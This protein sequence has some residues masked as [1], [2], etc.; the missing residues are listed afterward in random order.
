MWINRIELTNWR[1]YEHAVFNIPR[2]Q[3]AKTN[4]VLIGAKNG[5][6]KTSLLEAVT[7]CL[8]GKDGLGF[9]GR[10]RSGN[11]KLPYGD[12]LR[13]A[14][15]GLADQSSL[16]ASAAVTFTME[17]G[18][19]MSVERTWHFKA[20]RDFREDELHIR[21][22]GSP[23]E[24]PALADLVDRAAFL[25][26]YVAEN[27]LPPSLSPFFLFDAARVQQMAR[28]DM[29]EQVR[30]GI[31]AILGVPVIN[32]VIRD[33]HDYAGQRYKQAR[34]GRAT[35][36]KMDELQQDIDKYA[37]ES[38]RLSDEII[39]V[40]A[41]LK[42][43]EEEDETLM[44]R[45]ESMGGDNAAGVLELREKQGRLEQNQNELSEAL[46]KS[47][48]G[49]FA[50]S[51][52]S[53]DM[54]GAAVS[55]LR[56][57][58]S[59]MDWERDKK[60]GADSYDKFIGNLEQSKALELPLSNDQLSVL[61]DNIKA[62]WDNVW[63]PMP[64]ECAKE[65][66]STA[67][68]EEE[69]ADAIARLESLSNNFGTAGLKDILDKIESNKSELSVI[70][71]QIDDVHGA[72]T[73]DARQLKDQLRNKRDEIA[74]L[75]RK[76]GDYAREKVSVDAELARVRQEWGR[77]VKQREGQA[78][79]MRLAARA[80][81]AASA[82]DDIVKKSYSR[83]VSNIAQGMTDA[84]VAMAH[85]GDSISE[86][87]IENDCEIKVMT[88]EGRNLREFVPSHGES[89]IF[90]LA[91]IA[92]IARVAE[93]QFPFIVDTPLANLDKLHQREFL[94]YFSSDMDNQIILLST[95]AEIRDEH[96]G[97]I[98]RRVAGKFLV[99]QEMRDGVGRNIV[100]PG[101]YFGEQEE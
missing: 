43:A 14:F 46:T 1:A 30:G 4:V 99:E 76:K 29:K 82:M 55:R 9:L 28:S 11:A 21:K 78:P 61:R 80:E 16:K 56:A 39:A 12:F 58:K 77:E 47:L 13:G 74:G 88:P 87:H 20:N 71:Q 101:Q 94:R 25:R 67:L 18:S 95:D 84:F 57:E 91:L 31:E 36:S 59:R 40:E 98:R 90:S 51:L 100:R 3:N 44:Q 17:G 79:M 35:D 96:M 33:L 97:I 52:T 5:V 62:A 54:L 23:I 75:E 37:S 41:R 65:I 7:L 68:S 86:I 8:F 15:Y 83:H 70:K 60:K 64:D 81:S 38:K 6:G 24:V 63:Y 32:E 34:T 89:E 10:G 48:I 53:R 66:L 93:N 2:P 27:F 69:R 85:K 42:R 49:D 73:E 72:R 45:Y 26:G 22:D 19:E 50:M 92:A